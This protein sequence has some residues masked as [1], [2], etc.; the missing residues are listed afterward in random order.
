MK[1]PIGSGYRAGHASSVAMNVVS[2]PVVCGIGGREV[3]RRVASFAAGLAK[4]LGAGLTAVRAEAMV[5]PDGSRTAALQHGHAWLADVLGEAEEDHEAVTRTVKIGDPATALAAVAAEEH[6]Q[7]LVVGAGRGGAPAGPLGAVPGELAMRASC[8]VVVLPRTPASTRT[9]RWPPRHLLCAFDG[10][11]GARATLGVAAALA[12]RL[13][14]AA[15]VAHTSPAALGELEARARAEQA[16]LIVAPSSAIEGW[17]PGLPG[18]APARWALSGSIPLLFVP[19][20]YRA[21]AAPRLRV[22]AAG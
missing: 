9:H 14:T 21:S 2:G 19:P 18:P 22:A 6:A 11:D 3:G 10:S 7:L 4:A 15:F 12:E 1:P 16:A 13:E 17:H 5:G 20:T 8:P